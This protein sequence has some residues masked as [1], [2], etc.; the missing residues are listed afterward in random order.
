MST[1]RTT[2]FLSMIWRLLEKISVQVVSFIITVV[3]AR[4]LLPE[5]YG[6]IALITI[7]IALAEVLVDGGLNM[8]LIQKKDADNTDFST[9]F[10]FS[11][12]L[13]VLLYAILY[14][15]APFI[16]EFYHTEELIPVIRVLSLSLF[17]YA[18]NSIQRAYVSRQ[19]MFRKMFICNLLAV[20]ISGVIGIFMAYRGCGVWALVAQSLLNICFSSLLMWEWVGWRPTFSFSLQRFAGL[21]SFGWKIFVS[22]FI[23]TLF[24]KI[25]ALIIGRMYQPATLAYYEKGNQFPGLISDTVSGAIQSVLFP[26]FSEAQD[27]RSR[28][29]SM[30]RRSIYVT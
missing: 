4:L 19:M 24:V 9:V 26:V 3:L 22:N 6:V 1:S 25:R 11:L 18:L 12:V 16:A 27:D 13:S 7:F 28:I 30:M 23:V 14:F 21:F 15:V 5:Q 10:F 29:K 17:F 8:A 20:I 2:I